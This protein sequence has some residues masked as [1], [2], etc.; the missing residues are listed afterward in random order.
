MG[1]GRARGS[2]SGIR[3]AGSLG[4]VSDD[5]CPCQTG[6]PQLFQSL[7]NAN[8][9]TFMFPFVLAGLGLKYCQLL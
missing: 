3:T 6:F 5:S 4:E 8:K 9:N 1:V 2:V 7:Q